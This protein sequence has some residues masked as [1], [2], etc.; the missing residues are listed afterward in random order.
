MV[1]WLSYAYAH[2]ALDRIVIL[3]CANV[4]LDSVHVAVPRFANLVRVE[5]R[6]TALAETKRTVHRHE[7]AQK[8]SSVRFVQR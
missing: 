1:L 3:S 7:I 8:K 2:P 6:S 5:V 4:Y